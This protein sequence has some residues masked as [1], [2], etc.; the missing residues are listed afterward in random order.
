YGCAVA[1]FI[2]NNV[3][4]DNPIG[5]VMSAIIGLVMW[6][7]HLWKT[8]EKFR[9]TITG[10]WSVMKLFAQMIKDLVIGRIEELLK[11]IGGLG[12]AIA[13]LF[14]GHF[15]TAWQDAK[16]AAMDIA[17]VGTAKRVALD[18]QKIKN[19]AIGDAYMT[20]YGKGV[21]SFLKDKLKAA[22]NTPASAMQKAGAKDKTMAGQIVSGGKART[23]KGAGINGGGPRVVTIN[24]RNLVEKLEIHAVTTQ[25]GIREMEENV[26]DALVRLLNSANAIQT[27]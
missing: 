16:R 24:L 4:K 1:M 2:F 3:I 20:G 6:F 14:T 13:A 15:G 27:Q 10:I 21:G 7:N 12:K 9:A 17:G 26:K 19:G 5:L 23:G 22:A 25:Q 18:V 11:G 8:S